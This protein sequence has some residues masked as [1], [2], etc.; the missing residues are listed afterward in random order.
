MRLDGETRVILIAGDPIGQVKSPALLSARLAERGANA[1]VIPAHVRAA[2]FPV[3][4]REVKRMRNLDGLILTIPHKF[5]ALEQCDRLSERARFVGSANVIRRAADGA[6]EGDNCDGEG[7]LAGVKRAGFEVRGKA[8]LVVGAGG[9]GSAIAYAFL[10]HGAARV[11]V[12][13]ADGGRRDALIGRLTAKFGD[14]AEKGSADPRGFGIVANATPMGMAPGDPYPVEI[15]HLN[16]GQ[17]V[18][19]VITRPEVSP[20]VAHARSI[21][22]GTMTGLGMF[23]GVADRMVEFYCPGVPA[24][25]ASA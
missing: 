10:E 17:F 25:A 11:A 21:G 16:G 8:V 22:C 15:G 23:E 7:Y 6:W 5:A 2:D 12:H 19:C 9:A 24:A 13:D 4:A 18:A 20:L 3:F 14:R 1:L